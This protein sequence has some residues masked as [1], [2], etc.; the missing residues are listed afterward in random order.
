MYL[1]LSQCPLLADF[2]LR[3]SISSSI[4]PWLTDVWGTLPFLGSLAAFS[5]HE[6]QLLPDWT[7]TLPVRL[8]LWSLLLFCGFSSSP[9]LYIDVPSV[10]FISLS[11]SLYISFPDSSH[12]N[13]SRLSCH[14]CVDGWW[15][16]VYLA[17]FFC[18]AQAH[19]SI[20]WWDGPARMSCRNLKLSMS[21]NKITISEP[22]CVQSLIFLSVKLWE[23][24]C[25][26]TWKT[27]WYCVPKRIKWSHVS[28]YMSSTLQGIWHAASAQ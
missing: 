15:M 6:A 17:Q 23:S 2:A 18:F 4:N 3:P 20:G 25:I 27:G 9:V 10:H 19:I 8:T 22:K 26:L 11:P 14:L 21:Q 13:C 24:D 1:P 7:T 16:A 12:T 5:R 28:W